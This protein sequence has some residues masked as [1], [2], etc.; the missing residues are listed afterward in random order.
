[1]LLANRLKKATLAAGGGEMPTEGL[2]AHYTM[3]SISGSTL[4]DETGSHDGTI[5]GATQVA[6][7]GGQALDFDGTNDYVSIPDAAA[8]RFGTGDFFISGWFNADVLAYGTTDSGV[9]VSKDYTGLE[10]YIYQGKLAAYVGGTAS[11]PPLITIPSTG[12][13]YFW[14]ITRSGSSVTLC[15]GETTTSID[16]PANVSKT[17]HNW[18]FGNRSAGS[19]YHLNG[20]QAKVRF[21]NRNLDASEITA[22]RNEV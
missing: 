9:L 4:L 6:G 10:V 17:G 22:L 21:Y 8:L 15:L 5:F 1:M 2:V 3:E 12:M 11:G 13:D 19:P 7:L 16:N 14:Y 20:R 18:I